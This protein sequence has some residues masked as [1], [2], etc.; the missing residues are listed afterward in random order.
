MEELGVRVERG[1][2]GST[3]EAGMRLVK[4]SPGKRAVFWKD[5]LD[6]AHICV[7]FREAGDLRQRDSVEEIQS[8]VNKRRYNG[9]APGPAKNVAKQ[10]WTLRNL[11]A[12]DKIIASQG[13]SIVLNVGTVRGRYRWDESHHFH[14]VVPVDWVHSFEPKKIPSQTSWNNNT[15]ADVSPALFKLITGKTVKVSKK[16]RRQDSTSTETQIV[17][18]PTHHQLDYLVRS[19]RQLRIAK[20]D[21][22][23]LVRDY[24]NWLSRQ[25]RS[26]KAARHGNLQC[27]IFEVKR[28]ILIEAKSSIRREHIRMAVGQLLDYVF[29]MRKKLRK[30][31]MAILLP[32]R[33]ESHSVNWLAGLEIFLVWRK[34]GSSFSDNANGKFSG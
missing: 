6:N 20:K 8:V 30:P 12:G 15:V 7:G 5:C 17:D 34:K 9:K 11:T 21:E 22:E 31:R 33:P 1:L 23:R 24:R 27:D 28:N 10:L 4:V 19:K 18:S 29:Q 16:G 32:S 14:H 26:F 3:P 25:G 13:N 2:A